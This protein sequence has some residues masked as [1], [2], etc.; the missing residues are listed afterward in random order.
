[1]FPRLQWER[2]WDFREPLNLVDQKA[3]EKANEEERKEMLSKVKAKATR[4]IFLIRHGQYHLDSEERNLTELGREQAK[5]VGKR[6]AESDIKFDHLVKSTMCRATE[7]A[8]IIMEQMPE[9][10]HKSDSIIEE[11]APYPPEPPLSHWKPAARV[12]IFGNEINKK[13]RSLQATE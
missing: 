4:H 12:R 1:M 13:F 9:L 7:T 5:L 10:P 2:D 6:L 3:Y 11:G 8:N